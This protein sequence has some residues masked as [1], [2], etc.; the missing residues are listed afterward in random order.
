MIAK[1]DW[2]T[3]YARRAAGMAGSDVSELLALPS[4][5]N[6][7]SFAGEFRTRRCFRTRPSARAMISS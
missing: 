2:S 5:P 4:R 1:I 6:V 7:V 3:H